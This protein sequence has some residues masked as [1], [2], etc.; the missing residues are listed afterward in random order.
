[1]AHTV[2]V[3]ESRQTNLLLALV[4]KRLAEQLQRIANALTTYVIAAA[5]KLHT[6]SMHHSLAVDFQGHP[7]TNGS[8]GFARHSAARPKVSGKTAFF[9]R[10]DRPYGWKCEAF[11]TE[12]ALGFLAIE[13]ML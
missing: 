9:P 2:I 8:H 5:V 12:I 11:Q 4:T 3:P 6:G 7:E 13:K 10:N 1:M